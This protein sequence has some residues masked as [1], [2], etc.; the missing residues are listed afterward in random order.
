[1]TDSPTTSPCNNTHD[2]QL[3]ENNKI[4]VEIIS[5]EEMAFIEAAFSLAARRSSSSTFSLLSSCKSLREFSSS[6]VCCDVEDLGQIKSPQKKKTKVSHSLLSRF[7]KKRGLSVTDLTSTEWCEKQMEF[8]LSFGRPEKTNAMKAGI[9]RHAKLEEEVSKKVEVRVETLEDIWALKFM[10]FIICANQILFD[11]LTREIPVVGFVQGVWMVGVIDELRM[12]VTGND[13]KLTLVDTKTRGQPR[14]PSEPQRR[15]GRLQLMCY[16]YLLD[17]L[18][19]NNFPSKQFYEHFSMDPQ[20]VLSD[21]VKMSAAD[22]GFPAE[23]LEELETFF[24]NVCAVLPPAHD[25]L[26]LRELG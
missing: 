17:N 7:R 21:E 8:F 14:L 11:G 10:N 26:L 9:T 13:R 23:T 15:N 16:K 19:S 1:M 3:H 2:L 18:V 5:D 12:P 22:S 24:N 6:V 4:P 25:Q 20:H